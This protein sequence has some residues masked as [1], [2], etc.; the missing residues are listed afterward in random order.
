MECHSLPPRSGSGPRDTGSHVL[1]L[2]LKALV[3][4]TVHSIGVVQ[5]LARGRVRSVEHWLWQKQLRCNL[6]SGE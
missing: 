3:L 1:G 5:V 2:K 4:D 6:K